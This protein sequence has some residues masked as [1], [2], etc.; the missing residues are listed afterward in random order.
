MDDWAPPTG[1]RTFW[2]PY[3]WDLLIAEG[4]IA[5]NADST[6]ARLTGAD[7]ELT[8]G[9]RW[10]SQAAERHLLNLPIVYMEYSGTFGDMELV[11]ETHGQL[12]R[13]A[14]HLRRRN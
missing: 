7:T 9:A 12:D 1:H 11:G 2:L 5:L 14:P 6:V 4:Y 8:T 3:P 13:Q 10:R